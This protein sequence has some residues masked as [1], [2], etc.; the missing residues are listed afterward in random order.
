MVLTYGANC[1]AIPTENSVTYIVSRVSFQHDIIVDITQ[2]QLVSAA[3]VVLGIS[4]FKPI[5]NK[6]WLLEN[7][8][9]EEEIDLSHFNSITLSDH[10]EFLFVFKIWNSK[11]ECELW[12]KI[13]L[14]G[15]CK[16][17]F[18]HEIF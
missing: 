12:G 7:S 9:R 16:I 10:L 1:K 4:T 15:R 2:S 3:S 13:F 11:I 5:Q 14:S 17:W 6:Q 18:T 8:F